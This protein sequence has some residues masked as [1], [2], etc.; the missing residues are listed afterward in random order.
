MGEFELIERYFASRDSTV[1]VGIG[2]DG[3]VIQSLP[4]DQQLVVCLDTLV[5]GRHFPAATSAADIGWKALAVNL[6]DLA[7]MGATPQWFQLGLTLPQ[8]DEKWLAQFAEG[9]FECARVCSI[10]L[11]GGDT[12]R[13]PLSITVQAAGSVPAGK[14][15]L[16]SG[17][18]PGDVLCVSGRLGGA[19]LAL[20]DST[21]NAQPLNRPLARI[22]LGQALSGTATSCIDISDG[23]LADLGHLLKQSDMGAT[24]QL[25][26]LPL[27]DGVSRSNIELALAGGDDYEL[28]FSLPAECDL[29]ALAEVAG[30]AVSVIGEI[31]SSAGLRCIDVDGSPYNQS[32]RGWQHF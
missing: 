2:D 25:G 32:H 1:V 17:A 26:A 19:A 9:L 28:L 13:G 10:E 22:P 7:A 16:R 3:A 21:A 14:A 15:L 27:A 31:Q 23:L 30:C 8:A 11:V 4:A 24:L 5:A 18:R 6:S 20:S 29:T 12:T